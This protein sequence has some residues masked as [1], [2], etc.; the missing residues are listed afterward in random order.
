MV[1]LLSST[2]LQ[3]QQSIF[4]ELLKPQSDRVQRSRLI[5]DCCTLPFW[6]SSFCLYGLKSTA[7]LTCLLD[8]ASC[9][10]NSAKRGVVKQIRHDISENSYTKSCGCFWNEDEALGQVLH[11]STRVSS[12]LWCRVC[13]VLRK[14]SEQLNWSNHRIRLVI[15]FLDYCNTML[16]LT[17]CAMAVCARH[18]VLI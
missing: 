1:S 3:Q 15:T 5:S 7:P 9:V 10:T 4:L 2:M 16:N 8:G 17:N 14:N 11:I 13:L 12:C 18:M 6:P